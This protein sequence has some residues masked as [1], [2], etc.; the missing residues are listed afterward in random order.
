MRKGLPELLE[1]AENGLTMRSRELFADLFEELRL[2]DERFKQ[3]EKQIEA[4]NQETKSA[5]I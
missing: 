3:S 5:S 4:S 2:L 1:D